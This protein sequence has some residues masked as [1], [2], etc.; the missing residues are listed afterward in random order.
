MCY[1]KCIVEQYLNG[2]DIK[3]GSMGCRWERKDKTV[4]WEYRGEDYYWRKNVFEKID[5]QK[6]SN[7]NL[8]N[9]SKVRPPLGQYPLF[10]E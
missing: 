6:N 8:L 1:K 2:G 3:F 10:R 9:L 4:W 7:L 5:T